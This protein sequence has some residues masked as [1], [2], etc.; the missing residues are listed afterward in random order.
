MMVLAILGVSLTASV[1]I[2]SVSRIQDSK[3]TEDTKVRLLV[4][5]R[6]ISGKFLKYRDP[7]REYETDVAALPSSLNDLLVKP[8]AVTACTVN[9]SEKKLEGWC[10]PYIDVKFQGETSFVDGWGNALILDSAGRSV[11]SMGPDGVDNSGG[12]DDLVQTF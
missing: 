9:N 7:R 11:R 2:L 8:A 6:G 1:M 12:G 5:A 3:A 10:G 4:V